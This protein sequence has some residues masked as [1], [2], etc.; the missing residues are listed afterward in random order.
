MDEYMISTNDILAALVRKGK[1]IICCGIVLALLLG[2]Y[3]GFNVWRAL[4]DEEYINFDQETYEYTK[5]TLERN[6]EATERAISNHEEYLANSLWMQINPYD[7]HTTEL[8]LL[9]SGIDESDVGMTFGDTTTPRDYML[10]RITAQYSIFWSAE[11]LQQSLGIPRYK[12]VL[13]KYIRELVGISFLDGGIICVRAIGATEE[14]ARELANAA[15]ALLMSKMGVVKENSFNHTIGLYNTVQQSQ[16]DTGMAETQYAYQAQI[17][18]YNESIISAQKEIIKLEKPESVSTAIIKK[19]IIGGVLGAGLACA[20]YLCKVL[21]T[22]S[23]QSSAQMERSLSIPF[24]GTLVRRKGLFHWLANLFAGE[25]VWEDESQALDYIVEIVKMRFNGE[26]LLLASTLDLSKHTEAV[27]KLRVALSAAGIKVD[28][29]DSFLHNPGTPGA[30][31]NCDGV[32]LLEQADN[33]QTKQ[34]LQVCQLAE[35]CK[36]NVIGFVL[37]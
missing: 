17:D 30:L 34:A 11:D 36:K 1:Q 18:A 15:S 8:Y 28:F 6:I 10:N 3:T 20:W 7:K 32:L 35:E 26:R 22:N 29:K 33:T 12:Q 19:F 21:L 37:L 24:S 5:L 4:N 31:S 9:I 13:D 25:R 2:G 27:E 16:I 23:V 14:E